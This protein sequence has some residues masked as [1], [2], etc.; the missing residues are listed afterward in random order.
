MLLYVLSLLTGVREVTFQRIINCIFLPIL[1]AGFLLNL[2]C[3][4]RDLLALSNCTF[5]SSR[6]QITKRS[7]L[8]IINE[9]LSG[10][11]FF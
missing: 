5:I 4:C 10:K 11:L 7:Y 2:R 8:L 6:Q 1:F 3:K 9:G